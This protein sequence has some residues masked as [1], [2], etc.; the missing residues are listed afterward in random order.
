[1]KTGL[2]ARK[3]RGRV[4]RFNGGEG[5]GRATRGTVPGVVCVAARENDKSRLDHSE[6]A[7]LGRV[8]PP[9]RF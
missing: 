9:P 1:M 5:C 8:M 6:A 3:P 7:F 2:F 4:P